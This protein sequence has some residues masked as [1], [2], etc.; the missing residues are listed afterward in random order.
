MPSV[1]RAGPRSGRMTRVPNHFRYGRNNLVNR[2][3]GLI[4]AASIAGPLRA[5]PPV[6]SMI[7]QQK[8][9]FNAIKNNLQKAAEKMPEDAYGF[10]PTPE[11]QDF[12]QRVGHMAGMIGACSRVKGGE[13]KPN[14]ATGKTSKADLV[15]A[16]K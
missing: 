2:I 3:A 14:P 12:G 16:L 9:A 1:C 13:A 4:L 7:A 11:L 6:G 15:A 8:N 5:Q 10:K